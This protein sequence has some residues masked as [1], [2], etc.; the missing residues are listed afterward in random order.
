MKTLTKNPAAP[1]T[2]KTSSAALW[3]RRETATPRALFQYTRVFTKKAAGAILWDVDGKRYID[4]AGGIGTMNVGHCHPAVV[5]AVKEQAEKFLHTCFHVAPYEGYIEVCENLARLAPGKFPKKAALFN[6]GA[7]AVENA[8]KFARAY[9]KR[10]AI[11]AFDLSFHGRTLMCLTLTGKEKPYK[12]GF[13]PFA[14][15]VYHAPY[16]YPY[17]PPKGVKPQETGAYALEHLERMFETQVSP[18]K[19][20]AIIAEP[21]L[22]EGGFVVPTPDFWPGLRRLCDRHGILLIADEIQTGFGRTGK[23]FGCEHFGVVP[24]LMTVAKS[25]AGGLPLSGV[26]GRADV[27]DSAH[28][29]AIGGTYGG[30]PVACAAALAVFEV[31]KKEKLVQNAVQTG[32][33]IEETFK[34]F[35]REFPIVGQVRGLGAMQAIEL[36]EDKQTKKPLPEEKMK[37]IL[38]QCRQKGLIILKSGLYNNVIRTLAPLVISKR[39]LT[40][41]LD[42]LRGALKSHS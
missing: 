9:T 4:F 31:F 26:V 30:N 21:V 35:E 34:K 33:V 1:A 25:L 36:V 28:V 8:V 18:D 6:S 13:G 12:V 17:R 20:A 15:E 38:D 40:Q 11:I 10:Q 42:I 22:G 3:A 29:G 39:D 23:M 7:E 19:V 32:R 27:L 16:P 2:P 41:G 14:P 24:D 5:R 37:S